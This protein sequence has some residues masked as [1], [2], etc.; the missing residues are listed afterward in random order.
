MLKLAQWCLFAALPLAVCGQNS[1]ARASVAE[2]FIYSNGVFQNIDFPGSTRTTVFGIN[3][4]GDVVGNYI[5]EGSY[6]LQVFV[7]SNGAYQTIPIA[8]PSFNANGINDLGQ[9]VGQQ[10]V[11]SDGVVSRG[12]GAG[13]NNAGEIIGDS[14][15]DSAFIYSDGIYQYL[16]ALGAKY[17]TQGVAINN[18]GEALIVADGMNAFFYNQGVYSALNI[19]ID[20]CYC[21]DVIGGMNDQD[22]VVLDDCIF[23]DG[24]CTY[25]TP[26]PKTSSLDLTGIMIPG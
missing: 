1:P 17:F 12:G 8:T 20:N 3:N 24:E 25:L 10:G 16:N 19:P 14:N 5:A 9:I 15:G 6:S 26:P 7:Y 13:I 11:Y 18:N 22:V 2:S 4:Q 21:Q 23:S